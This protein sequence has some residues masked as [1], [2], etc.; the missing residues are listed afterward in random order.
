MGGS[1]RTLSRLRVRVDV[2][3]GVSFPEGDRDVLGGMALE[4]SISSESAMV[5]VVQDV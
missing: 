5:S 3:E 1:T 4:E 2:R